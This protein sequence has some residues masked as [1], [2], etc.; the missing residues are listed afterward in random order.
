MA[1]YNIIFIVNPI[2]GNKKKTSIGKQIHSQIDKN[3]YAVKICFTEYPHH[4]YEIAQEYIGL[5]YQYIVAVGGDGTIN[6]VASAV[7]G[8]KAALGIIPYGSGN[9]LARHLK[10]PLNVKKAINVINQCQVRTLDYGIIDNRPFFCTCGVGFDAFISEKFAQYG[11]RG[12]RSYVE[13]VLRQGFAYK[14]EIY[15]L[16]VDNKTESQKAFLITCANASQYGNNAYIAPHASMED[17][18][19]DIVV[20][21]PFSAIEAPVIATQLFSKRLPSN[22]HIIMHKAQKVHISRSQPGA[23]HCDGDP[24]EAGTE[25]DIQLISG[26]F[27]V[28][29]NEE[30]KASNILLEPLKIDFGKWWEWQRHEIRKQHYL[31]K[32]LKHTISRRFKNNKGH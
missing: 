20:I 14:S 11:R 7:V 16:S 30:A 27:N 24:F 9:G 5:G 28:I 29:V 19:M 26:Q 31:I 17:G 2:S 4:A 1:L 25:I 8:T 15:D 12:L 21:T 6:E 13:N 23:I 18:L 3:L 32:K 22:S 10:I